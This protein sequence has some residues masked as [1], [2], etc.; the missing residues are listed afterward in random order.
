[1]QLSWWGCLAVASSSSALELHAVGNRGRTTSVTM[2]IHSSQCATLQSRITTIVC[3]N[4]VPFNF[5]FQDQL[6]ECS[7][8]TV[9]RLNTCSEADDSTLCDNI[10]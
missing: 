1:M 10:A 9:Y 4:C 7:A 6:L 8:Y 3:M 2:C 5:F